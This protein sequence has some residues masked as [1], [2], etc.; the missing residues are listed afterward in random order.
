MPRFP[1][2]SLSMASS[3]PSLSF[4][5]A[6]FVLFLSLVMLCVEM[7]EMVRLRPLFGGD[8]GAVGLLRVFGMVVRGNDAAVTDVTKRDNITSID[9][10][11]APGLCKHWKWCTHH[12]YM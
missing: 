1:F 2:T 4:P 11:P 8:M 12:H 6:P 7:V 5:F 10:G 3:D 9:P